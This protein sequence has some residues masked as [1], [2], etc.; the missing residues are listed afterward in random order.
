MKQSLVTCNVAK[1]CKMTINQPGAVHDFEKRRHGGDHRRTQTTE[2]QA[3]NR[4]SKWKT[5]SKGQITK[6]FNFF[7]INLHISYVLNRFK[8]KY[9]S[10]DDKIMIKYTKTICNSKTEEQ[11]W[12]FCVISWWSCVKPWPNYSTGWTVYALLCSI[13]LHFAAA[14]KQ[15]LTSYTLLCLWGSLK[16]WNSPSSLFGL[17]IDNELFGSDNGAHVMKCTSNVWR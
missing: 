11:Q 2:Q 9:F 5:S 3:I 6:N 17:I 8:M 1:W 4:S 16:S 10:A 15:L 12:Q 7:L 14:Q 13:Q